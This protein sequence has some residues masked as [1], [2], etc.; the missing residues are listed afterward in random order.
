MSGKPILRRPYLRPGYPA[1]IFN[2]PASYQPVVD[3]PSP[4]VEAA[5]LPVR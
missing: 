4:D 1:T 2:A 3:A 5:S